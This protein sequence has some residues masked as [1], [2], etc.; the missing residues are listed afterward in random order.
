MEPNETSPNNDRVQPEPVQPEPAQPETPQSL[1]PE[2]ERQY[3]MFCHLGALA[4]LVGIPLAGIIVPL[5]L[6]L[7][8]KDE[9]AYID[10]HG[11][12][13]LNFNITVTL[14]M[15]LFFFMSIILIGIPLLIATAIFWLV[16]TIIAGVKANDGVKYRYPISLRLI[17]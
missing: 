4:G 9:S 11:K 10:Y 14:A 3:A 5:V 2:N 15:I 17:S 1:P 7:L 16:V 6:W 13:A 12:E 8:K